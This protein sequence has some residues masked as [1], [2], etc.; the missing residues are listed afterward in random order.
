[1]IRTC[2]NCQKKQ[3]PL[4]LLRLKIDTEGYLRPT[5]SRP[6]KGRSVWVCSELKCIIA[7]PLKTK[8]LQRLMRSSISTKG[9]LEAI[10]QF[11]CKDIYRLM[12]TLDRSGHIIWRNRSRISREA[13]YW[14]TF[15]GEFAK[16][17]KI[18][19]FNAYEKS[20]PS[21]RITENIQSKTKDTNTIGVQRGKK[22]RLLQQRI[23]LL[24]QLKPICSEETKQNPKKEF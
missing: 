21:F 6:V 23:N 8:R 13:L 11:L 5:N 10:V 24:E 19:Y 15:G 20:I 22:S 2:W 1:M 16:E 12:V 3:H 14:I 17:Q 18:E 4:L 9:I 7:I